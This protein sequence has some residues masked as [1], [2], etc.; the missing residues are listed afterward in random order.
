MR[1]GRRMTRCRVSASGGLMA[2][3]MPAS[4][5]LV[6]TE[7]AAGPHW[8]PSS[9]R[10]LAVALCGASD[11]RTGLKDCVNVLGAQGGWDSATAWAPGNPGT[12]RCS[13][14]WIAGNDLAAFE[15]LTWQ[16]RQIA[17]QTALGLALRR[18]QPTWITDL[19]DVMDSRLN[20]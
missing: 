16:R 17:A 19:H 18:P 3:R 2:D 10:A 6:R 5:A 11:W 1:R 8:L 14:M 9:Q 4:S 13:A 20:A 15:T 7:P 12:L